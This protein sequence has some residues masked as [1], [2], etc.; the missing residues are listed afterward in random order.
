VTSDAVQPSRQNPAPWDDDRDYKWIFGI[1]VLRQLDAPYNPGSTDNVQNITLLHN[2]RLGQFPKLNIE[3]EMAVR[4][5]FGLVN[6]P[7][8]F[9]D[10]LLE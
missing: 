6:P 10:E 4:S 2:I 8:T 3:Q 7:T 5:F 9:E 1:R